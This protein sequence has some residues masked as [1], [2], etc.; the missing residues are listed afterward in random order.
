MRDLSGGQKR[1][2]ALL[3]VLLDEPNVLVLDE[4]GNDLDTDMFSIS[5]PVGLV[6]IVVTPLSI[7]VAGGIARASAKSFAAQQALQGRLSGYAEEMIGNQKLVAVFAHGAA[8]E[9][10]YAEINSR[11]Y[12][13]GERAQFRGSLSNPTTRLVN[14]ITY[15]VVAIVGCLCV[16]TSWPSV[17]TVGQVQSF[18]SYANQYM[19]DI[20]KAGPGSGI[21]IR[22]DRDGSAG[23]GR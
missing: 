10:G 8:A 1:R 16:V 22:T 12:E 13:A 21:V 9:K 4:P 23:D 15:A 2:L 7:V 17:L 6:V 11:L 20:T 5:V 14:N 3:C 19:S 18:L